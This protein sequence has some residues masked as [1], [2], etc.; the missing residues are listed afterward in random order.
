MLLGLLCLT[1]RAIPADPTPAKVAQPDGT[2]LTVVLHGDEFFHFTTTSDGYTVVK[3]AAGYYTYALLDGD[4]LVA[5]DHIARDAARRSTSDNAFLAN[6][7]KRLIDQSKA[8]AGAKKLNL[9]NGVIRRVG[10]EGQTDY[11]SFRG[12]IILINY[13]D[14]R[15]SMSN[16]GSFY[17]D[18]VN[19]HDYTGYTLGNTRV[20]MTGSVRDYYYD[21]SNHL[22]DPVFDVVGP[23]KVN[24]SST[25]PQSTARAD[26][27]FH[28]ALDSVDSFIDFNDYDSDGDGYV[29]MV[30]FLVAGYS[31][32]YGGNNSNYLWP[33]MWYLYN[34]PP[35]DNVGLG[36]YACSTE[37]AGWEGS[38]HDVNGIGTICHEFS[39]V[40]GL[41]DLYDTDYEDS[42]GESLNPGEWS[43]MAKGSGNNFGRNPVG[44]SLYERYAL[45]FTV[46]TVIE[47]ADTYEMQPLDQSNQGYRLNTLNPDEFFLIENRQAGKWDRY[48]PG[49]G[50]LVVRVDSTNNWI[51]W[52]N[53]VNCNPKRMYYELLRADYKGKDSNHDP[54]PGESGVTSISNFSNPS[55]RPWNSD[56]NEYVINDI[57]EQN[58]I[59]TFKVDADTSIILTI[60]SFEEMPITTDLNAKGVHGV[61]SDWDFTQCAVKSYDTFPVD[62]V[63][64]PSH[65]VAMKTPSQIMTSAPLS[66]IP[67]MVSFAVQNTTNKQASV[68]CAYSVDGGQTWVSPS[69]GQIT[70]EPNNRVRAAV[71]LPTDKPI[72]LRFNQVAGSN[73]QTCYLDD[74]KLYY[75][76]SW[77][78]EPD[79]L[80]GDVDGDGEVTII[81]VNVLVDIVLGETVDDNVLSRADVN[82]DKEITVA[83]INT[84]INIIL[85]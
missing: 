28:A 29:D 39:H 7:P 53:E 52:N 57:T 69:S 82:G 58:G 75:S 20:E 33:H 31:A 15:F 2:T 54:F 78:E 68:K 80:L 49:H 22:F 60:E 46:P 16:P 83:D 73:K 43:I 51:W 14:R 18:M 36:L 13:T 21:N 64:I 65:G 74:I 72:M 32:N 6:V 27:I 12:L 42:G 40:L 8:K 61:F 76:D 55:L 35:H 17:D 67:Y 62:G 5:S 63:S 56:F 38:W 37:I 41:P 45:G 10:A 70:V 26:A 9:R 4:R 24:F 1:A 11:N 77:P 25:Y 71:N 23:V 48:L 19:T 34:E 50:M 81:D 47:G 44:Y 66:V 79:A 3:N 84:L 59:V 85:N 30:F